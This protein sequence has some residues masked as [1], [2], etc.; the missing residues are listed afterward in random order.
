M[1]LNIMGDKNERHVCFGLEQILKGQDSHG[2]LF[3]TRFELISVSESALTS[4]CI[5]GFTVV[6]LS[7]TIYGHLAKG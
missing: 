3:F 7:V 1:W 5:Y 6:S 4:G 2:K